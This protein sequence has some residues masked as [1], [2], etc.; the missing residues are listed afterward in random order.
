MA[1]SPFYIFARLSAIG[2]PIVD[3][4]NE[5]QGPLAFRITHLACRGDRFSGESSPAISV[6]ALCRHGGCAPSDAFHNVWPSAIVPILRS[7]EFPTGSPV[8]CGTHAATSM[9]RGRCTCAESEVRTKSQAQAIT[10]QSC[11]AG[12]SSHP[13]KERRSPAPQQSKTVQG[14]AT[15]DNDQEP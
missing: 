7:F 12:I 14:K 4:R 9:T 10:A 2:K 8:R 13:H 5:K 6:I 3:L 15:G 1:T 11:A